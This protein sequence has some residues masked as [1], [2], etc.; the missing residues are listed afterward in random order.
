MAGIPFD[1]H[2]HLDSPTLQRVVE[3]LNQNLEEKIYQMSQM[4]QV[5][6]SMAKG[7]RETNYFYRICTDFNEIFKASTSSIFW[8]RTRDPVGWWLDAWASDDT[9][10]VP[11]KQVITASEQGELAAIIESEKPLL[12]TE[13]QCDA[14]YRLWKGPFTDYPPAAYFPLRQGQ[15]RQGVLVMIDPVFSLSPKSIDPHLVILHSLIH[16]GINNRLFYKEMQDSEEEFR[17]LIENSSDMVLV[18]YPD[19]ILRDSNLAFR[20]T[21]KLDSD[22]R[23]KHIFELIREKNNFLFQ[24][25][26]QKLLNYEEVRNVS[27]ELATSDGSRIDAELSGNIRTLPDGRLG[28]IRLYIR[29]IS[30]RMQ[31]EKRQKELESEVELTR[32]RQLAQVGM[33]VSGIAHNLQNPLQVLLGYIDILKTTGQSLKGLDIIE[34]STLNMVDIVRNL[35]RKM[36]NENKME[37]SWIDVNELIENELTFLNANPF[38]KHEVE[39]HIEYGDNIP[40]IRGLYSDFSQA[41]MNIVYN[42]LEAISETDEKSLSI[43]TWYDIQ[44]ETINI[45]LRDS[46]TG[47][48]E[49]LKNK[50]FEAFFTTKKNR[51]NVGHGISSGSGLGLSSTKALLLTY[52]GQVRFESESGKGTTFYLV[53]PARF[54]ESYE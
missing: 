39:K 45:T 2:E 3:S 4:R 36:Q 12:S 37:D 41:I 11:V 48:P 9:D 6:E 15:R 44:S 40:K 26:W 13:C 31:A 53:I 27:I 32:Q 34:Q 19:G 50:I 52:G 28:I 30:E 16:T 7:L 42:S 43:K 33:Y 51:K 35:L 18:V 46:G 54:E 38:F 29:D 47:I 1:K 24:Q 20:N 22:P 8:Y 21:L 5:A 17:D 25:S 14:L 23:G 10:V 49:E